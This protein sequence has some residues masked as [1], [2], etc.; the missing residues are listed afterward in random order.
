LISDITCLIFSQTN[1]ILHVPASGQAIDDIFGHG[2]F[3]TITTHN[4]EH[5]SNR[6][7][8]GVPER[9]RVALSFLPM[10]LKYV[11][12][13]LTITLPLSTGIFTTS[14]LI[15]LIKAVGGRVVWLHSILNYSS[16]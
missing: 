5:I 8:N 14:N 10:Q 1:V 13:I 15:E 3:S 4:T 11:V 16:L 2:S 6:E 7:K 9:L 12:G